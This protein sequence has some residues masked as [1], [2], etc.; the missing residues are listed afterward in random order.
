MRMKDG[1]ERHHHFNLPII[2]SQTKDIFHSLPPSEFDS[3]NKNSFEASQF[4]LMN[5][6]ITLGTIKLNI[7]NV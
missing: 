2:K 7:V 3:T 4:D 1:K 6:Q 5:N